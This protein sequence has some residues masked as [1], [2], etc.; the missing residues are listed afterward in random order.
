MTT[1][2]K[3]VMAFLL[4]RYPTDL[5]HEL[6]NARVTKMVYLA[7]W[8]YAINHK[9]QITNIDWYFDTYGPFVKDIEKTAHKHNEIFIIDFGNNRYGRP[10]KTLSLRNSDQQT[11]LDPKVKE[12]LKHVIRITKQLYWDGFIKIVYSSY[13]VKVSEKYSY[14]DLP[15]LAKA[16]RAERERASVS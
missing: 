12:S 6:S 8:H 10:K 7:D 2:L 5:A 14:L 15:K 3:D 9:K 11:E 13:P 4:E 1:A 16:F